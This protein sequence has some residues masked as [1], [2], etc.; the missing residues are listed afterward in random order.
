MTPII[1]DVKRN[2]SFLV[3]GSSWEVAQIAASY[4]EWEELFEK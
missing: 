4:R 3:G 2:W 1:T